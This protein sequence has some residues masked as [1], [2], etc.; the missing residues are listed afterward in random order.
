[1][2]T[3]VPIADI[4]QGFYSI[5][6]S[7]SIEHVCDVF[8]EDVVEYLTQRLRAGERPP[9]HIYKNISPEATQAF[10]CPDD[11]VLHEAYS[12]VRIANQ[13]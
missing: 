5:N 11:V 12:R 1:L 7:G 8:S 3:R 4:T 10:V 6:S 9:L 2:M 13:T